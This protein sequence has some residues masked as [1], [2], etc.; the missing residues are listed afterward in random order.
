MTDQVEAVTDIIAKAILDSGHRLGQPVGAGRLAER[1]VET[2]NHS[3]CLTDEVEAA[4]VDALAGEIRREL[5]AG[6]YGPR[7]IA[8]ELAS[9]VIWLVG[10]F[11]EDTNA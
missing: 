7:G 4:A 5:P 6:R 3:G 11:P 10:K 8:E 2:L 1:V 9:T